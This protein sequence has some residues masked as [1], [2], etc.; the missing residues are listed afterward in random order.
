MVKRRRSEAGKA[1]LGCLLVLLVLA[2]AAYHGVQYFEVQ[3]RYYQIQDEVKTEAS[4]ATTLS[5]DEIRRRLVAKS[6][7][8][9]LPL[10]RR[11]W[12]I[13]RSTVYPMEIVISAAYDDSVVIQLPGYVKVFRFHFTPGARAPL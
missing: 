4:Y 8:L 2:F 13:R 3:F 7:S 9:G 5:N 6:D 12:D 11:Q 1:R 10:G